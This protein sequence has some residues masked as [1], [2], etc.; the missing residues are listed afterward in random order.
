MEALAAR[1]NAKRV[2]AN[3]ITRA[4]ITPPA[5]NKQAA[6]RIE[7]NAQRERECGMVEVAEA[8]EALQEHCA[9]NDKRFRLAL[10]D[11]VNEYIAKRK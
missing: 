1:M 6:A 10:A 8:L 11:A 4:D 9:S 5:R 3:P 2:P 7:N